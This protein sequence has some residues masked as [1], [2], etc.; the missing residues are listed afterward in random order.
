[1]KFSMRQN[2]VF[3]AFKKPRAR[4]AVNACPGSG[5]TTTLV[6]TVNECVEPMDFYDTMAT[7][8]N[9]DIRDVMI[10]K[11]PAGTNVS[12]IHKIGK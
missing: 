2:A 9:V 11:F 1:M 3:E 12:N 5:K 8:F 4:V 6:G 7:C 10:Q